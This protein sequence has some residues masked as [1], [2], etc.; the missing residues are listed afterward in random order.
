MQILNKVKTYFEKNKIPKFRYTQFEKAYFTQFITSFDEITTYSKDLRE[1]LKSDIKLN[2]LKLIQTQENPDT[3]KFLF[4]TEDKNY[5]ESVLLIHEKR[6]TL[7]VS[8]QIFCAMGCKFCATGANKFRRNLTTQ[9]IIEQATHASKYLKQKTNETITNIVYM[10]MGEPFLNYENVIESIKILN[11]QDYFNIGARHITISTCGIIPRIKEFAK[12]GIQIRLAISLHAPNNKIRNELMPI[13][14]TYPIEK[15]I[16]ATDEFSKK[17]NKRVSF[18]YVL[19][20]N[21]N[22]KPEHAEELAKLLQK[23]LAHVNLLIYNPHEFADF[24]KPDEK[25]V[26]TFKQILDNNNI[27]CSIR[28][29]LG[30]N[31]DG[32]CGQLSG[33]QS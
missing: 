15:L 28:K 3:I 18:E 24:E 20:K 11:N 13:N 21:I 14:Q 6:R 19:I 25:T 12:L 22:D 9:E 8:S 10:G 32:A 27:E 30:D 33:K 16:K 23:K 1:K 2:Q 26:K 4:E 29:S 31:I 17:T 7:C 5:I